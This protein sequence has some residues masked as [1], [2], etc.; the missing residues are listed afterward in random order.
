MKTSTR[1]LRR[2]VR[3][4]GLALAVTAVVVPAAH[5]R[6]DDYGIESFRVSPNTAASYDAI[7]TLRVDRPA[8]TGSLAYEM[9]RGA[10][11]TATQHRYDGIEVVRG[12]PSQSPSRLAY[13][14]IELLRIGP[15]LSPTRL[16]YDGIELVRSAPRPDVAPRAAV[17]ARGF[18][19]GDA[20]TGAVFGLAMALDAGSAGLLF[21]RHRAGF[22]AR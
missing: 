9:G 12:R 17:S 22:A 8:E 19:W 7:E 20:A 2:L 18:D 1:P 13:D 5:A 15:S 14:G 3:N 4:L 6:S 10:E 16:P 11:Q 21:A